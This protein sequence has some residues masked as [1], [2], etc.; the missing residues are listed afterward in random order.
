MSLAHG[1]VEVR[2]PAKD[3]ALAKRWYAEKLACCRPK[4]GTAVCATRHRCRSERIAPA[5]CGV[6]GLRHT[7]AGDGEQHRRHPRQLPEQ[8]PR[9]ARC[10]VPRQRRQHA[11]HRSGHRMRLMAAIAAV[12]AV[13]S[14]SA[15]APAA[16]DP[17]MSS[18]GLLRENDLGRGRHRRPVGPLERDDR[19]TLRRRPCG[20]RGFQSR[21]PYPAT[22]PDR[23]GEVRIQPGRTVELRIQR[24][25]DVP[26]HRGRLSSIS[27]PTTTAPT[28]PRTSAPL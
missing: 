24:A 10:V 2:L 21:Q 3:L 5:R 4:S 27:A 15:T 11:R 12:L 23:Q 19:R 7:G 13:L 18:G 8:R 26:Q 17:G 6:R 9:R 22:E 25:S 16:A 14:V 1:R 20:R 28:R